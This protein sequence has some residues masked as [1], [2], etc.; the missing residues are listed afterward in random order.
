MRDHYKKEKELK[1]SMVESTS[2]KMITPTNEQEEIIKSLPDH[3]VLKINAFAG[4][5]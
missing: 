4:L 2:I 1:S 5:G 3:K